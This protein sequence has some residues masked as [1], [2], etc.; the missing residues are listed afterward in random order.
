MVSNLSTIGFDFAADE[1]FVATMVRLAGEARQRLSVPGGD[2]AIWRSR[3]G[4]EIWFQ[5]APS[6]AGGDI[7]IVGLTPFFEGM[8]EVDL[9]ITGVVH[10][11]ED[12]PLDGAFT[13]WVAPDDAGGGSYPIVFDAV[14]F[15]AHRDGPLPVVRRARLVAFARDLIAFPSAQSYAAGGTG[16][17]MFSPRSFVPVGLAA[18]AF[19]EGGEPSQPSADARLTGE[20]IEHRPL[21][22]EVTGRSFHWMLVRSADAVFDVVAD[23]EI[24]EGQ[25]VAG[26][27]VD[28]GCAIFGRLLDA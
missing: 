10:R 25:I 26:G 2:Y 28:V 7:E 20:V 5:L 19:D 1:D 12:T 17:E 21:I 18:G 4:A 9:G 8:S 11:A 13:A 16:G 3:T 14:D 27:T 22:N 15:G 23:P 6:V 24:I